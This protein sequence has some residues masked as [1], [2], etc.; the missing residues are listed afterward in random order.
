MK[1]HHTLSGN[2]PAWWWLYG[3]LTRING[4]Y[5]EWMKGIW[6]RVEQPSLNKKEGLQF[7]LTLNN[8]NLGIGILEREQKRGKSLPLPILGSVSEGNTTFF[9]SCWSLWE[10]GEI[11]WIWVH[12]IL[13]T[14]PGFK[15][16]IISIIPLNCSNFFISIQQ[17]LFSIINLLIHFPIQQG[18]FCWANHCTKQ[19]PTWQTDG[20]GDLWPCAD[21]LR[22]PG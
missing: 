12:G 5:E 22:V 14:A 4:T 8:T 17:G 20:R 16:M 15:R 11:S 9:V 7:Q 6:A 1:F 13:K 10:A 2:W 3:S 19:R 18:L 21:R